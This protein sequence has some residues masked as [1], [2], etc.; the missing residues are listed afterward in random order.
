M[1]SLQPLQEALWRTMIGNQ[2]FSERPAP[3]MY[4]KVLS[5]QLNLLRL[6]ERHCA[7]HGL[8][9]F[10]TRA[11]DEMLQELGI[12]DRPH[13]KEIQATNRN[14]QNV[15]F[16]WD[17]PDGQ[18]RFA[19]TK[20]GYIGMVPNQSQVGDIVCVLYDAKVTFVQLGESRIFMV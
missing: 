19:V 14:I 3:Q 11:S 16:L 4:E 6:M 8:D 5:M 15:D 7:L 20:S 13:V 12:N 1:K 17:N 18:R 9:F 2:T 10:S